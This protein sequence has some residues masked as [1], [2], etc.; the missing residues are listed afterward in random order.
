VVLA[1]R[2]TWPLVVAGVMMAACGTQR[3]AA[4]PPVSEV[5]GTVIAGPISPVA[6]PGVPTTRPVRRATVE[7]QRG[8]EVVAV[9]RTDGAGR[10]ELRLPPGTYVILAKAD[11]YFARM[12]SKTVTLSAGEIKKIDLLIDTGI[13]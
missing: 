3:P 7:A 4:S 5:T 6:R 11:R 10:Y 1:A 2:L 13:R 8:T 12:S 9:A